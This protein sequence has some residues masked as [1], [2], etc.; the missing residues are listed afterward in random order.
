MSDCGGPA[1]DLREEA[2]GSFSSSSDILVYP[3]PFA[4][5]GEVHQPKNP[6]FSFTSQGRAPIDQ[7]SLGAGSGAE[8][9][10][11]TGAGEDDSC[12]VLLT[13]GGVLGAD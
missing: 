11:L 13:V 2:D 4:K 10:S 12:C 6:R 5:L 8:P 9:I 3:L 1:I 7:Y